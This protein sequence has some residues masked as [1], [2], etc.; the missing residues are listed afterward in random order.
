MKKFNK[1]VY[2]LL[3]VITLCLTICIQTQA[4]IILQYHHVSESSPKSTS[5]SPVQFEKHLQYLADNNFTVVPLSTIIESIKEQK[6]LA[7][8]IVSITFDDAYIDNLTHAKPLLD[9]FNYPYTIFVNPGTINHNSENYLSWSQLKRLSE[10]GVIIANHG[11]E[12]TSL[13]RIPTD[14]SAKDWMKQQ[15]DAINKAEALIKEKTGQS[16]HYFAYPYG[17]FTQETEQWLQ[18]NNYVAFGQQSGAVGLSTNLTSIPRFPASQPYDKLS[19]LRD[20]LN[21][22]PFDMKLVGNSAK[23]LVKQSEIRSVTFQVNNGDFTPNQ[24]NCYV[25]GM[26]KQKITWQGD[27]N[28]SIKFAAHLPSGRVRANCTAPSLSKPGRYYW[29]SKPWMVLNLDGSWYPL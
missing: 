3:T 5:I 25:S 1:L 6:T 10:E 12:H 28:F 18:N 16:W 23:S 27:T 19:G 8:K 2:P 9:K 20:K 4:A 17:E 15:G 7:D 14:I 29:Y 26:G 21:S 13:A 11:F 22:L 24:L